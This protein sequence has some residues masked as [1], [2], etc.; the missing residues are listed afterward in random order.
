[1][2]EDFSAFIG[3]LI[4]DIS[5]Y[6]LLCQNFEE[7]EKNRYYNEEL[8]LKL[9]EEWSNSFLKEISITNDLKILYKKSIE[10]N[11]YYFDCPLIVYKNTFDQRFMVFKEVNIDADLVDFI[12][13]EVGIF[14][15]PRENRYLE[16]FCDL[17]FS[18]TGVYASFLKSSD[19][20][21]PIT[22]NKKIEF[23]SDKLNEFGFKIV[24]SE[25]DSIYDSFYNIETYI[26]PSLTLI[27][28]DKEDAKVKNEITQ[29]QKEISTSNNKLITDLSVPQLS[30]LFKM[31]NDLK[32]VIFK[33]E[34]NAELYRF[35]SANFK[36]KKSSEDG[37]STNK[38]SNEFGS[39][40]LRAIEFWEKHLHTMLSNLRNLK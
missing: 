12:K 31:I 7:A 19:K 6:N 13:N 25:P 40:N 27:P 15:D 30:L 26:E 32:P 22:L 16:V 3:N 2:N 18:S 5:E 4:K 20:M 39:P 35:I 23:L 1:M 11:Y 17:G 37:I 38:L 29:T 21:Y 36:T 10:H 14:N 9:E 28:I 33:T 24:L 34:S 8:Y